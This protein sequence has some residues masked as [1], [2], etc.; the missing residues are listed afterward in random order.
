MENFTRSS[1]TVDEIK[2]TINVAICSTLILQQEHEMIL[3][4]QPIPSRP[5][6]TAANS[7]V[8]G[9]ITAE[10]KNAAVN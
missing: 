9:D 7:A 10:V 5:L 8:K 2:G 6:E 4:L 1:N 3:D